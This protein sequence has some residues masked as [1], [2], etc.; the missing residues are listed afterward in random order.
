[1]EKHIMRWSYWLGVICVALAVLTRLLNLVGLPTTLLQTRGDSISFRTF[2]TGAVL[3]LLTSIATAGFL[4]F[5]R[6]NT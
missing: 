5:K 3:F 6:Q 1:M 4:W 2:L